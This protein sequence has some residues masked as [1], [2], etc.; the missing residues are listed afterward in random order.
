[1]NASPTAIIGLVVGIIGAAL[2]GVFVA[3][4]GDD[5]ALSDTAVAT[6]AVLVASADIGADV[7]AT[8]L[9][10]QQL[11]VRQVP[12]S[13]IPAAA[14]DDLELLR[15]QRTLR[16]IGAGEIITLNQFGFV[17]LA[18]G[19]LV[20][21]N[22]Y[23]AIS[24]EASMAPGVE[25]Y[26][27]PG[28][29]VN[30]YGTMTEVSED[31]VTRPFTQMLLGHVD[32][33]AVTRGTLDGQAA[34]TGDGPAS[35]IVLLL[36]VR[37][38]DAPVVIFAEQN[39]QL[40]YSI[41]NDED[42]APVPVRVQLSDLSPEARAAAIAEAVRLQDARDAEREAATAAAAAAG[43]DADAAAGADADAAAEADAA[44]TEATA[45]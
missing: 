24:V 22:G 37:T 21:E 12:D 25:G 26:I 5:T 13:L 29:R 36:E 9:T 14:V 35:S 16:P 6:T 42:P 27:I 19:G 15:G 39:A 10:N 11:A 1:M 30:I 40:W 43:G 20:V 38:E 41:A 17:G 28:T 31:G 3:G 7:Q 23:E 18:D 32:V 2:L 33:L 8:A 4:T 45:E 44:G 34:P